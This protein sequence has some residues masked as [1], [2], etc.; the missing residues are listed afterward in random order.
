[1]T[2]SFSHFFKQW[3]EGYYKN[4]KIGKNGDFYTA[5]SASRFFGG[6]IANFIL[7]HLENGNITLPLN[8][9]DLGANNL[10]LL[11]DIYDFLNAL[12]VD[13]LPYCEFIAVESHAIISHNNLPQNF[14]IVNNLLELEIKRDC[15]FVANEFFDALPCELYDDGKMAFVK[16]HHIVFRHTNDKV[17]DSLQ[18]IAEKYDFCRSE[19]PL[20]Y[21]EFCKQL[22]SIN[23]HS[24]RWLFL[25]FDYGDK[26]FSNQ[27]NIR[28]F[29]KHRTYPLFT[30]NI[31]QFTPNS[32]QSK[33]QS[34]NLQSENLASF[35]ASSDIT[36]NVPFEIL[37][38]A[39]SEIDSK[40]LLFKYQDSALI[41]DFKILELFQKFYDSQDS[42]SMIYLRESNKIKTLLN[43]LNRNFKTAIYINFKPKLI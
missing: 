27:F 23:P 22:Q 38:Q 18:N 6:A 24:K 10:N 4:A 34:E 15:V 3:I 32:T 42:N 13:V 20:S 36:Y 21:M 33:I 11:R 25:V 12:S 16:N 9:I 1:M 28:I 35:Y 26:H 14:K 5:V 19:I 37:S 2:E 7:N 29:H 40:E 17:L 43:V 30:Q 8:I 39:F 31:T 41:E